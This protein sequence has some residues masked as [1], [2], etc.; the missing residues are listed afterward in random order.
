MRRIFFFAV[1][2]IGASVF[3][4]LLLQLAGFWGSQ[5]AVLTGIGLGLALVLIMA[6]YRWFF[7]RQFGRA[8]PVVVYGITAAGVAM[9]TVFAFV[10]AWPERM[11]WL[12]ATGVLALWWLLKQFLLKRPEK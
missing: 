7:K 5:Q 3:T 10:L 8:A 9:V 2:A 12:E 1:A 4:G 11:A 6:F